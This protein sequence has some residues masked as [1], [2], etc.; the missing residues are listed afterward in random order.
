MDKYDDAFKELAK[1]YI[2]LKIRFFCY[3]TN[4]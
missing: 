1:W 2:F 3:T 4:W